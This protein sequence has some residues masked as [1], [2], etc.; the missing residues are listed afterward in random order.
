[1]NCPEV[2]CFRVLLAV[3][4]CSS[5][6]FGQSS[7]TPA[8]A[9]GV[10]VGTVMST[11]LSELSGLAAS[12]RN[13]GVLWTHNDGSR[14]RVYAIGTNGQ[15]FA[16]FEVNE[17][18]DDFEDI[19]LGPGPL[20]ELNY[21][22][23]GDIGD[24]L[25]NRPNFHVYRTG[26]P[27]VYSYLAAAP[28]SRNFQ[29]VEQFTFAYPDGSYDTEAFF[30]D[31]KSGDLYFTTKQPATRIYRVER[32][33]L[34]TSMVIT[35]NFVRTVF[36]SEPS[37]ATMSPD[38][39]EL[40]LRQESYALLWLRGDT[41]TIDEA[42]AGNPFSAPVIGR[43]QEPNGEALGYHPTGLGY[44]TLSEGPNQP[45]YFFAKTS[46]Y[47]PPQPVSLIASAS[48]WKYLDNGSD[49]GT[50]WR[51]P[52]FNAAS[53]KTGRAQ[54][55]Y[56][57]GDE[58]TL[59][60]YGLSA[61]LK[62]VTT[63]FRKTFTVDDPTQIEQLTVST[64]FDDGAAIYINGTEVLRR[65]L[66]SNAGYSTVA[67]V[68]GNPFENLWQTFTIT[69]NLIAG[70]NSIAVEVHRRSRSEET[71][72]F[73]LQLEALLRP[74]PLEFA[75]PPVHLPDGAWVLDV[76]GPAG[77]TVT[78]EASSDFSA[79]TDLTSVMLPA[80]GA[81]SVTND[82]GASAYSFFRLRQ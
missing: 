80:S 54:F 74:A 8:F 70:T 67:L 11:N 51:Q 26:E 68:T 9:S 55:G 7:S 48:E 28:P 52:A 66:A 19:V 56:G 69:N 46:G 17:P 13:P 34:Q 31:P 71:L 50:A 33:Q 37:A 41:Q 77:A 15:L 45:I 4:C 10:P 25:Y 14:D 30:C 12:R 1:M 81:A 40:I 29:D 61:T 79:W 75:S 47:I 36:F 57:D 73:D 65:N 2:I 5:P 64:V 72:S 21:L 59:I 35:C 49:Q 42:L 63:Y 43:P 22:Y 82:P 78:V 38:G 23:I 3:L 32:A 27:A 20:P 6:A 62:Y 58:Q 44:Y 53:W 60:S 16:T 18:I 76:R 39:S 24:N